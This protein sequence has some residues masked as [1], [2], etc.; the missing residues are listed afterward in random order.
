MV[1][2]VGIEGNFGGRHSG[3]MA[4]DDEAEAICWSEENVSHFKKM[5]ETSR[6]PRFVLVV[7]H[8]GGET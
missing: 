5:Y 4:G 3:Y 7:P 1:V 8:N 2:T 6:S